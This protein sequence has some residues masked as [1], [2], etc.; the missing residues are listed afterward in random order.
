[1]KAEIVSIGSELL[2]G[3][4]IDT[5]APYLAAMLPN[6]GIHL[7]RVSQVNDDV[8]LLS[9]VLREGWQRSD[10]ILT[11]GG[12]GPTDDDITR[13]AIAHLLEEPLFIDTN[14]AHI[15][16]STYSNFAETTH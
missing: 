15:N 14:A 13:E 10:L 16:D 2:M 9:Q 12:L 11:T 1:M 3:E 4:L 7:Q 5:N 6:L 8:E